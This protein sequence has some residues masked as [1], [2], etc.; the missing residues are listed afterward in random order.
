MSQTVARTFLSCVLPAALLGA[1]ALAIAA[2]AT[3]AHAVQNNG[4]GDMGS[5]CTFVDANR[6]YCVFD[7]GRSYFCRTNYPKGPEECTPAIRTNS[8]RS[9]RTIPGL[10]KK[11]P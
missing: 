1:T 11:A 4:N 2:G 8:G 10:M 6:F 5:A 7:N 3:P 9:I